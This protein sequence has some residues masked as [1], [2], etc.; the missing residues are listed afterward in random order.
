MVMILTL[1]FAVLVAAWW[2]LAAVVD[3]LLEHPIH[4]PD[5]WVVRI[6][7]GHLP[8]YVRQDMARALKTLDRSRH[9]TPED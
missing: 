8:A 6:L 3:A 2:I 1:A 4:V 9:S 7:P 5:R